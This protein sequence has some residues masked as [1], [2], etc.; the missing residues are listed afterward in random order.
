M[1]S[2]F[3][4][5]NKYSI[6]SFTQSRCCDYVC[7]SFRYGKPLPM[8]SGAVRFARGVRYLCCLIFVLGDTEILTIKNR[9]ANRP[10]ESKMCSVR[11]TRV[12]VS[13]GAVYHN[14]IMSTVPWG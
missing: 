10:T 4:I 2:Q 13:Q 11:W 14:Y 12:A 3:V 5:L 8:K 1:K 6:K 7:D 9:N